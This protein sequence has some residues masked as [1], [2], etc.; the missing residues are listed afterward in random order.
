MPYDT[1]Q[2]ICVDEGDT[3]IFVSTP[4]ADQRQTSDTRVCAPLNPFIEVVTTIT[5][6]P[7]GPGACLV[8]RNELAD[9]GSITP[10]TRTDNL[11]LRRTAL[12]AVEY[13]C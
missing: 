5:L 3:P 6:D 11:Q 13:S 1:G 2:Q 8:T 12:S 4:M 10:L 7:A 9:H